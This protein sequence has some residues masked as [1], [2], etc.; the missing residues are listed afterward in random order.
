M[1]LSLFECL[2]DNRYWRSPYYRSTKTFENLWFRQRH[3][4]YKVSLFVK[5]MFNVTRSVTQKT[6]GSPFGVRRYPKGT[7]LPSQR[8]RP[9]QMGALP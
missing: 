8:V 9:K 4:T 1:Q 7:K 5:N 3:G 2:M 6:F